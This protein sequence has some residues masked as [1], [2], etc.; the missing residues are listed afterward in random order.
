[1]KG[2]MIKVFVTDNLKIHVEKNPHKPAVIVEEQMLT[3]HELYHNAS[4]TA[5]SLRSFI[6]NSESSHQTVAILADNSIEYLELFCGIS[7]AGLTAVTLDPKWSKRELTAILEDSNP[8]IVFV[9]EHYV[10]MLK[11]ISSPQQVMIINTQYKQCREKNHDLILE[12]TRESE[13]LPFYIGFTSGTTGRPKGYIRSHR[14]WLKSFEGSEYEFHITKED[15]VYIPG[16]LVHSLFLYAAVHALFEGCTITLAKAFNAEEAVQQLYKGNITV[17]YTVPTMLEAVMTNESFY[18]SV[19][20]ILCAGAKWHPGSKQRAAACFPNASLYEFFGASETS[21]I[22]VL[23]PEGNVK[24]PS[25]VGRPFYNVE[26]SIRTENNEETKI[27]EIGHLFVKS[28]L[29]F[30]GYVNN[31]QETKSVLQNGWINIGDLAYRDKEG[32]IFLVGRKK[33]MIISGGLNVYPE[34]VEAVLLSLNEVEEVVVFGTPD[35]YWG[36][37]VTACLKWKKDKERSM[38]ELKEHCRTFL[39]SY[40]CPKEWIFIDQFPYTPSGKVA[41]DKLQKHLQKEGVIL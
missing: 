11:E 25:S 29:V 38:N 34:E 2:E 40:K 39:S 14:S 27:N 6:T 4:K 3:Y 37:K 8:I 9:Q 26:V 13:E 36:E 7:M 18:K 21:F 31:E 1:M 17:L 28:D 33:N 16:P 15:H 24:K 35:L 32:Y 23:D 12:Q 20:V 19:K 41:R 5:A 22:T 30:S 10:Y